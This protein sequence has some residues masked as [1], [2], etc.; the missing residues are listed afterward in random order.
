MYI[1]KANM[2]K[3][4]QLQAV[5]IFFLSNFYLKKGIG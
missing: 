5:A 2:N 3:D 4:I 1:I